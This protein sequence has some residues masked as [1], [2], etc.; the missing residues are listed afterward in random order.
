MSI[1]NKILLFFIGGAALAFFHAAL[2]TVK[3]YQYWANQSFKFEQKIKKVRE[4][5]VSLQTADHQ[6]PREDK[7]IGVQQLQI[8]LG[9][10]LA[11]RG[12]IWSKCDKQKAVISGTGI[13][14]VTLGTDEPA[15]FANKMIF[16]AFEEG[17]DQSPGKYLGEYR[18][19][20]VSDKQVVLASTSKMSKSL[21]PK[22][23]SMADHVLESKNPWILY[24]LMPTDQHEAFADMPE[25]QRKWVSDEFLNDGQPID[26]TGKLTHNPSDKKFER[27]L[28]DYLAIFRSCEMHRTLFAD[29]MEAAIRDVKYLESARTEAENLETLSEKEKT[30]VTAQLQRAKSEQTAVASLLAARQE[31][32]KRFQ[33]ALQETITKN[34]EDAQ[35]IAR[36][37]KEAADLI[38]RRTRSMAQLGPGT[39]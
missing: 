5:V 30:E 38:D 20:Q 39:N 3:T 9:R 31:V 21:D 16:Y 28:R 11:N 32:L 6:H 37:Q 23:K 12:R 19:D 34:A 10:V 25:E 18:V 33:V 4:E 2:R 17:D 7:T 1:W 35:A 22:T 26:A 13:M 27:Q 24:E 36:L 15:P 29:R 14:T 8:D